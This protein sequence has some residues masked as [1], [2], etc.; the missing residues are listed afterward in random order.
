MSLD[1]P[2]TILTGPDAVEGLYHLLKPADPEPTHVAVVYRGAARY[3]G[4]RDAEHAA[5]FVRRAG[6][7][8]AVIRVE[9][10]GVANG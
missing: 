8:D 9:P 10:R 6:W 4:F 7:A 1:G 3:G 5:F 2:L